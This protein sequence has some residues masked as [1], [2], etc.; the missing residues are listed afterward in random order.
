MD[1]LQGTLEPMSATLG[2]MIP[3][4]MTIAQAV[5]GASVPQAFQVLPASL[6]LMPQIL[7]MMG[8]PS[9]G[10]GST[11][12]AYGAKSQYSAKEQKKRSKSKSKYNDVTWDISHDH[13]HGSHPT[14]YHYGDDYYMPLIGED[15]AS[16]LYP[17]S[18]DGGVHHERYLHE[19]QHH[20]DTMDPELQHHLQDKY[21]DMTHD[22]YHQYWS[23]LCSQYSNFYPD[24]YDSCVESFNMDQTKHVINLALA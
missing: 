21:A 19:A 24:E 3:P 17:G 9:A 5:L 1:F 7:R 10:Q 8:L 20:I 14:T 23:G 22:Y 16:V 4:I 18:P 11:G 2:P 6:E 15:P 12:P 13:D